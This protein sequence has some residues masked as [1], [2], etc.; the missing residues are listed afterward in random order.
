MRHLVSILFALATQCLAAQ[1]AD[2]AYIAQIIAHRQHYKAEFIGKPRSPLT[3]QDTALLDFFAPDP[4][5]RI[6][7]RLTLTPEAQP[8]DMLTYSGLTR[9]YRQYGSLH[10]EQSG[11]P[12]TL[13]IYQNLTLM[14]KDSAAYRDYL[15]LPFKDASN[16]AGTYGGGRYLDFRTG[17]VQGGVLTLDF[18]KTYNPYCAYSDGYNCPIPPKENHLPLEVLAGEK[19]F[20]GEKKH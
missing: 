6:K 5:W 8:F 2:T 12:Y 17:D 3:A 14:A 13:R 15:F 9:L 18:N 10:F 7:A 4:A 1:N 16:G 20:R 19:A 11:K